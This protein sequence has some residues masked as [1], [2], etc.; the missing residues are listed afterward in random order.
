MKLEAVTQ[1]LTLRYSTRV[2][3]GFAVTVLKMLANGKHPSLAIQT[4]NY[5]Q[6]NFVSSVMASTNGQNEFIEKSYLFSDGENIR[7]QLRLPRLWLKT[8]R[9][10]W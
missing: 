7:W 9:R 8:K 10:I 5:L 6:G 1:R 2:G 3:Y 4:V